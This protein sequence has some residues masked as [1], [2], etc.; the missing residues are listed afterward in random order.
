MSKALVLARPY[1]VL[2]ILFTVVRF[3]LGSRAVPYENPRAASISLVVLTYVTA[4]LTAA[5]ARGL[6]G[7]TLKEAAITGAVMGFVSQVVIFLATMGSIAAGAQTYFNNAQAINDALIGK[8][9]TIASALPYRGVALVIAPITTA[10]SASI[11]WLIG[12]TMGRR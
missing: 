11:G 2:L 1:F 8:E 9:V 12:A 10:I 3:V 5:L 6:A 7:L 4:A